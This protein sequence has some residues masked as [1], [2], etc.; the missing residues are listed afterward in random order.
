ME[1]NKTLKKQQPQ[2]MENKEI[3][4]THIQKTLTN[5]C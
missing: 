5:I 4:N 3:K 2:H 1:S